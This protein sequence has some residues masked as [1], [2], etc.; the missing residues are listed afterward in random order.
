MNRLFIIL[1]TL[2]GM[3]NCYAA[4]F[5]Y[6]VSVKDTL[7]T[8]Y[9]R[10]LIKHVPLG[11]MTIMHVDCEDFE[12]AFVDEIQY[13]ELSKIERDSL[14]LLISKLETD[15]AKYFPDTRIKIVLLNKN[16]RDILCLGWFGVEF[17][18]QPMKMSKELLDYVQRLIK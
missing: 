1:I 16:N 5:K 11:V 17:N 10:V 9:V 3:T 12:G 4:K 15:P 7:I 2:L 8:E 13:K 18:G 6:P 14:S